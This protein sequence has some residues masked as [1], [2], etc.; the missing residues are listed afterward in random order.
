MT[1]SH[2]RS[3]TFQLSHRRN[4]VRDVRQRELEQPASDRPWLKA[5]TDCQ[6]GAVK[7]SRGSS[8][9]GN[10]CPRPIPIPLQ[11]GDPGLMS[12]AAWML[13]GLCAGAPE[14]ARDSSEDGVPPR[15]RL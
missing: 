10:G 11:E 8:W 2:H 7:V 4:D 1:G 6:A 12:D 14:L 13:P 9:G 5:A 15:L 3:E